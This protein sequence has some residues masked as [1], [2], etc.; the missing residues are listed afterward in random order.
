M[1]MNQIYFSPTGSTQKVVQLL[2][3]VWKEEQHSIDISISKKDYTGYSFEKDELCIIGVPSFGGRVPAIALSRLKQMK[4]MG[5]PAILV[6]TF[7]NRDYDDTLLELKDAVMESGFHV[8]AAIAAVTQ[9]SIMPKFGEGRPD[10]SDQK[11]VVDFAQKVKEALENGTDLPEVAVKGN[12]PYRE[13]NGLPFKPSSDKKCNNCG[14]CASSCP[15]DA[16]P[17]D[18]PSKIEK[19]L[20]ITCMRC[21]TICPQHA[22]KLNPLMLFAAEQKMQKACSARKSNSFFFG[23]TL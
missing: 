4:A 1:K 20:C 16:I 11:E 3:E 9:H 6:V 12:H 18:N 2:A 19:D 7:G 21:V 17:A 5:T 13:Y 8:V 15:V 14:L 10:S 22:R 23:K